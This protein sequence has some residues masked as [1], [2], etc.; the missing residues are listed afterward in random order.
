MASLGGISGLANLRLISYV[1]ICSDIGAT[2]GIKYNI[3][4]RSVCSDRNGVNLICSVC[5]V[6]SSEAVN[7]IS[8]FSKLVS[9]AIEQH[10]NV[11]VGVYLNIIGTTCNSAANSAGAFCIRV[12]TFNNTIICVNGKGDTR[13]YNCDFL[14][15]SFA[16]EV[17]ISFNSDGNN[18]LSTFA[19][20]RE[21]AVAICQRYRIACIC[22]RGNAFN[23]CLCPC[24]I[25]S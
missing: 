8:Y 23:L 12:D 20:S 6:C 15:I 18:I 19:L 14:G 13:I 3:I 2:I 1:Y 7:A 11:I 25:G 5:S 9:F 24:S 17:Y 16:M 4:G 10:A 22:A 21:C